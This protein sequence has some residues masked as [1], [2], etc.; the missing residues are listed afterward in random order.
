MK[1]LRVQKPLV[2]IVVITYNSADFILETLES[3]R[4]QTFEY[5]ELVICDDCS[6]DQTITVIK[7]WLKK[8]EK[9]FV[10][11][12]LI[13]NS[14]NQGISKNINNGYKAASG[15]WIKPIA[16]DDILLP[17]CIRDNVE[18]ILENKSANVV[19]S[20][21]NIIDSN[22]TLIEPAVPLDEYFTS[23][24]ISAENQHQILLRKYVSNTTTIFINNRMITAH[25]YCDESIAMMEDYPLWLSLTKAGHKIFYFDK[26]TTGYRTNLG[27]VSYDDK[28]KKI[29]NSIYLY[30][31]LTSRKYILPY[32][33]GM[34]LLI[35][36][37]RITIIKWFLFSRLNKKM[38]LNLLAWR[39]LYYPVKLSKQL[40][41]SR[42]YRRL[43]DP[44]VKL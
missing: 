9:F 29:I 33:N 18:F 30:N 2:S 38:A 14:E 27:S 15:E 21:T 17:N 41:L 44:S 13:R 24:E 16:G 7:R 31:I 3:V 8:N 22:S 32:L 20:S 12:S 39:T 11:V 36:K 35:E 23:P 34:E 4:S 28:D 19:Q 43:G 6:T 1:E 26:V 40:E 25:G 42:L 10:R 37:Y 5:L